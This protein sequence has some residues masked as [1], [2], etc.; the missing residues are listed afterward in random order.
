MKFAQYDVVKIKA[1]RSETAL[2]L[3]TFNRRP[4][5]VGDVA[6]IVEVRTKPLGYELECSGPDGVTEWLLAFAP[7]DIDLELAK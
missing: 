7:E 2:N 6:T 1:F 5:Q 3:D 4:P